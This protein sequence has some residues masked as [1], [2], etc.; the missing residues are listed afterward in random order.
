MP[1]GWR[2]GT[3]RML[4]GGQLT[5]A[6]SGRQAI[7]IDPATEEE[8][9]R[10]PDG[11]KQD[12]VAAVDAAS[13]AFPAWRA[14][15]ARKRAA[16]C[17]RLADLVMD[18]QAELG[19]LES[20]DT[21]NCIAPMTGDVAAG[22]RT[23]R[24]FAG[25]APELK[26][27]SVPASDWGLHFT[28]RE[29]YGVVVG[30]AAFN[31]PFLFAAAKIAAPLVAGNTVVLKPPPQAPLSSLALAE[32]A[33][34][35]FPPGVLNI[36]TGES[37]E[38]G[39]ALVADR[40]VSRISLTGSVPTGKAV[41]RAAADRLADVTLELGGKNP[42]LV[43]PDAEP[44]KAARGAIRAMNFAWQGQSC[45]STSRVLVHESLHDEFCDHV[46]RLLAD[47][48]VGS[49]QDP[50]TQIGALI[51][52]IQYDRVLDY[53]AIGQEEGARLLTGGRRP[54]GLDKGFYVEPTVF[55]GV[56][57]DMRIFR[58]EIFGP[59]MAVTA[60]SDEDDAVRLANAVD[61]GLTANLY[62]NDLPTVLRVMPRLEAGFV[63]VNGLGE[64]FLGLPFGGV[65]QSGLGREE[66]LEQLL[67]FT[68]SK[69]V[70]LLTLNP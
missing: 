54:P 14:T 1:E 9:A 17:T 37:A 19:E 67:S 25:L 13:A 64:H 42:L 26:G 4:I 66:G 11:G 41:M 47:M 69:S 62:T 49:P 12:A 7:V 40:R 50:Q 10:V 63:W 56:T 2:A 24:Y 57:E 29:P 38:L 48:H 61:Y 20:R 3:Y 39:E 5:E 55:D 68:Q 23:L 34:G 32:I 51:S 8:L 46:T 28:V 30:I 58:E 70:S 31:H 65:K 35:V 33:A 45:G 27:V 53:I 60:W 18:S 15:P 6:A 44:E 21:G 43:F 59:V 52:R 22:A 36:V 16:A